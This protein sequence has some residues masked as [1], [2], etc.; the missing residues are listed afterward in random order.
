VLLNYLHWSGF[1]AGN[2][3]FSDVNFCQITV[4]TF[5]HYYYSA[6]LIKVLYK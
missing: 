5:Y 1:Y 3:M 6:I 2:D 4:D